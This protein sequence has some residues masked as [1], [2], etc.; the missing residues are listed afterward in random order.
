MSPRLLSE[1]L[2]FN[3]AHLPQYDTIV[4]HRHEY[5]IWKADPS[6]PYTKIKP[7]DAV[8]DTSVEFFFKP[9]T[10]TALAV[11]LTLLAYVATTSDVL[12]EGHEKSL[13]CDPHSRL[14]CLP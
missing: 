1:G 9:A 4:P 10:L 2:S 12:E 8:N 14:L 7:F 6:E 5:V 11:A 13:L 3:H